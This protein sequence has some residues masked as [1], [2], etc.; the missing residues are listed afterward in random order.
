M[1]KIMAMLLAVVM[2]LCLVACGGTTS[3]GDTT[4]GGDTPTLTPDSAGDTTEEP[5][6]TTVTQDPEG[7]DIIMDLEASFEDISGWDGNY[8]EATANDLRTYGLGSSR[9][10]GSLPIVTDGY[11]LVF[12]MRPD[13]RV[14]DL[15]DNPLTK[16]LEEQTGIDL[17]MYTFAGTASD[18]ATQVN[19]MM[20]GGEKLPDII[21]LTGF[22]ESLKSEHVREGNIVNL[23]GYMMTDA[24]YFTQAMKTS[25]GEGKEYRKMI[26]YYIGRSSDPE[27]GYIYNF[28]Q[29]YDQTT[30]A[31]NT[32]VM[33]NVDWLG[34]LNLQ[35]PTNINELYDVLV[36]F[37]DKDPNGNGIK[38]EIPLVGTA[39]ALYR[40]IDLW[41]INA[42]V[43][44][45]QT[46]GGLQVKDGKVFC[47]GTTDAY[48]EALKFMKK[49]MD[50]GLLYQGIF[51]LG[52]T[53]LK[54]LLNPAP[55]KPQVVGI[56]ASWISSD[57]LSN[58]DAIFSYEPTPALAD[59]GF[60][61]GGYGMFDPDTQY[62]YVMV[63]SS[64]ERPEVAVRLLDFMTSKE[65]FLRQ[66]WGEKG[67]QWDYIENTQYAGKG[68][69]MGH[70]GGDAHI[71]LLGDSAAT[72]CRWFHQ[73]TFNAQD[74]WQ[75][76]L[77][78]A[79]AET[80]ILMKNRLCMQ[81][82]IQYQEAA[83]MPEESFEFW[84]FT[85]DEWEIYSENDTAIYGYINRA[86][87]EFCT[88]IRN[89]ESDTDW[90]IYLEDLAT[91]KLQECW[92]DT[93]QA[94][95]DRQKAAGIY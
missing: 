87:A 40:G 27:S 76:Y 52:H 79:E 70:M 42:F 75:Y 14:S 78:P 72:N 33:I 36:A 25:Y 24:P 26:E 66:R 3:F 43:Q 32:Q 57:W 61:M 31:V 9:W 13:Y 47:A 41:L 77:D 84:T 69:G 67:V 64:C 56:A 63:T 39:R 65:A 59:A 73:M 30:L 85:E 45:N 44:Y 81:Q 94:S 86:R 34:K 37:R 90:Q 2:L 62:N 1:K 53:E 4:L 18:A 89:P 71:V 49:L 8:E 51:T 17:E 55:G 93:A 80:S 60:G 15:N 28:P 74:V 6:D 91:L 48:R 11:K 50:E 88:G 7:S 21:R 10:D 35:K 58:N 23:A 12:G 82:N 46:I 54:S 22:S 95:Y 16:W 20:T 29:I 38:D 92:L 83:G 5:G 68:E 19:L